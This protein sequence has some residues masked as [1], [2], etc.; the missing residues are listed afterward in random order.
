MVNASEW[1]L[2][3]KTKKDAEWH[4]FDPRWEEG[5]P[6]ERPPWTD[7]WSNILKYLAW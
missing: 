7:D 6:D 2:V 1:V 4:I 3:A 5:I